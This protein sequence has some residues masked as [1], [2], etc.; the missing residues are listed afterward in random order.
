[1]VQY[2][3]DVRFVNKNNFVIT[4]PAKKKLLLFNLQTFRS[5]TLT[6]DTS[7]F[8][9]DVNRKS[10]VAL[11]ALLD[12]RLSCVKLFSD[13]GD[14]LAT[15]ALPGLGMPRGVAFAPDNLICVSDVTSRR[16]TVT[17]PQCQTLNSFGEQQ[18]FAHPQHLRTDAGGRLLVS[19]SLRHCV[20][21]CDLHGRVLR[22]LGS[23]SGQGELRRPHGL[24]VDRRSGHILVCDHDNDRI[25]MFNERFQFVCHLLTGIQGPLAVDTHERTD[26]TQVVVTWHDLDKG[27]TGFDVYSFPR[28]DRQMEKSV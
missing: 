16:V 8:S 18:G 14:S 7:S 9:C 27:Q 2:P 21:V 26:A 17:S 6:S 19:D 24:C 22:R 4:D 13:K 23:G 20:H 5:Q 1:M 11:I 12:A 25:S 28:F 15:I 3:T 10:S